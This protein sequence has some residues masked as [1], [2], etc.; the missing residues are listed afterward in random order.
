[1]HSPAIGSV[2]VA[3][4]VP[5]LCTLS[6]RS[7]TR[8]ESFFTPVR[9]SNSHWVM[10]GRSPV[11]NGVTYSEPFE[12]AQVFPLAY[13]EHRGH[14]DVGYWITVSPTSASYGIINSAQNGILLTR[15]THA[16]FDCYQISINPDDH[17]NIVCFTPIA[18]S[19]GIARRQ[20]DQS[21]L[22]DP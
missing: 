10:T 9:N 19:Y 11:I 13:G 8:G 5:P 7:G 17:H 20:L 16:L 3:N 18:S 4:E 2:T 12:A 1:Y 21:V 6:L 22:I 15:D 14:R